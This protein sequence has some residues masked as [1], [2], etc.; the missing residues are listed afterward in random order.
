[1]HSALGDPGSVVAEPDWMLPEELEG[2]HGEM[3][4][5]LVEEHLPG[6]LDCRRDLCGGDVP[7]LLEASTESSYSHYEFYFD[8]DGARPLYQVIG[9]PR[10]GWEPTPMVGMRVD[11]EGLSLGT[12]DGHRLHVQVIAGRVV[13]TWERTH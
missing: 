4:P 2:L 1:M 10:A 8:V 12:G 6:E 5:E 7:Y 3:T 11:G 13:W 9:V